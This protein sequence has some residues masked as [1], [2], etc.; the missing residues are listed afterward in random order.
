[1]SLGNKNNKIKEKDWAF[2]LF[3][4]FS[5]TKISNTRLSMAILLPNV[6]MACDIVKCHKYFSHLVVKY[7]FC[8]TF[9]KNIHFPLSVT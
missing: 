9:Y 8:D 5:R 1:M 7:S 2:S 4:R 3:Q 6:N